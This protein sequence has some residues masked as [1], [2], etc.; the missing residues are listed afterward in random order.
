MAIRILITRVVDP[1]SEFKLNNLLW[2]LRAKAMQAKGY[3]SG[4]TLRSLDDPNSFLVISTWN[5]LDDWKAWETDRERKV[6]Q[7]EIDKLL[8]FPSKTQLYIYS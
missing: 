1:G 5:S 3:I 6:I 8:R 7:D 2:Q 4:E